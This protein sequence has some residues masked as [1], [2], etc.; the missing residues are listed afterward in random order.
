MRSVLVV[1]PEPGASITAEKARKLGLH[2][3]K[4]PLFEIQ[5]VEWSPPDLAHF[6][7]L[8]FTS[9]NAVRFGGEPLQGLR[10]LPVYAVGSATADAAR[11]AGF[12][13]RSVGDSNVERLL[14]SIE[15]DLKLLHLAGEDRKLA[16]DARQQLSSITVYRSSP[17]DAVDIDAASGKVVLLH[18]PRAARRFGELVDRQSI[19]R[20][21]ILI[22]AI[23]EETA[24]AAGP[25]WRSVG[26]AE[27]PNDEALL[28]L[29]ERLCNNKPAS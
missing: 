23:S 5:P 13:I 22:A 10:G 16:A 11:E 20:G 21:S 9:A 28:A 25:G 6:D 17:K 19:E 8:L 4:V 15:P 12:D 7:G 14:G 18:S 1:R 29:T 2:C 24:E 3:A 26:V 27:A